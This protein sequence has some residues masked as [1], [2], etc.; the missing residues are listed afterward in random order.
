MQ[1][2]CRKEPTDNGQEPAFVCL[3]CHHHPP[4]QRGPYMGIL[5]TIG[6]GQIAIDHLTKDDINQLNG[7]STIGVKSLRDVSAR[8][9]IIPG[10]ESDNTR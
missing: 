9:C 1:R 3:K 5:G 8:V 6:L 7:F 2:N 4:R 10:S